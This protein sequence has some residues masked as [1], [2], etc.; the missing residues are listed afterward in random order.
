MTNKKKSI[1][2][3]VIVTLLV[4][5]ML[6]CFYIASYIN[7]IE[8]S[9]YCT[10]RYGYLNGIEHFNKFCED[11]DMWFIYITQGHQLRCENMTTVQFYNITFVYDDEI[12]F[13]ME[14]NI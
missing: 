11:R 1:E 8:C 12:P 5:I 13:V 9:I 2:I 3:I 14:D 7:D 4:T 6:T 10:E